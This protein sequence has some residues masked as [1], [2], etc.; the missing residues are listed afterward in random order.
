M[1]MHREMAQRVDSGPVIAVS[2][3]VVALFG[4]DAVADRIRADLLSGSGARV[5]DRW[6]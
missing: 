2:A 1:V 5:G 6:H 4:L 3:V